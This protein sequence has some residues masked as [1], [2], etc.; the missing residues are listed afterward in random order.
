MVQKIISSMGIYCEKE[1]VKM[2]SE[3]DRKYFK[4]EEGSILRDIVFSADD[5]LIT[6]F[7]IVAGSQGANFSPS[8]AIALGLANVLAGGLSMGS[9]IYLGVKSELELCKSSNEV[10]K[11]E[12]SPIHHGLATFISFALS[13]CVSLIPLF[14]HSSNQF[15]FS[16]ILVSV[17]LFLIGIFKAF[18]TKKNMIKSGLEVL[19]IGGLSAIAAY[20]VGFLTDKYL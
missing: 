14:I 7:A 20:M 5:G 17:S 3:M 16:V 2:N 4:N 18:F 12:G 13:G 8:V 11:I 6:T 10:K 1:Y 9:G 15:L 19:V